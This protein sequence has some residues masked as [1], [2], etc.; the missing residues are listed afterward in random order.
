VVD[1]PIRFG[2]GAYLKVVRP[3]TQRAIQLGHQLY[4]L[5]PRLSARLVS[6][7]RV[8]MEASWRASLRMLDAS[9]SRNYRGP[10]HIGTGDGR[11]RTEIEAM[12]VRNRPEALVGLP[13]GTR[14]RPRDI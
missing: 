6:C 7:V 11:P 10:Q 8:L 5:L 2:D 3:S 12:F 9:G 1:R 14:G 13:S 4:G